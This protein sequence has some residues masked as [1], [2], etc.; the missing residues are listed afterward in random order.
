M[1]KIPPSSEGISWSLLLLTYLVV[2]LLAYGCGGGGGSGGGSNNTSTSP[3][4]SATLAW[5]APTTNTD[6]TPLTDIAGYKIYYGTVSGKYS[7]LL[8]VGNVTTYKVENLTVGTTYFFVVTDY[9]TS[10]TES[11]FSNEVAKTV[12]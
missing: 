12:N 9:N 2:S 7:H 5:D 11:V 3:N 1:N 10:G 8:D 6:G 4:A